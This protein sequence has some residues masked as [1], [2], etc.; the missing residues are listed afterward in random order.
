MTS[1]TVTPSAVTTPTARRV[2]P[3]AV[4]FGLVAAGATTT[5]AA[6]GHAAGISLDVQGAPIPLL[7]FSQVTFGFVLVGLAIAAGLRRWAQDAH[8]AWLVTTLVLTTL[9]FAPDLT[10]DAA[11][12]TRIL[13]M[14]TH[15]TAAAIVI[16]AV[17]SRL[18]RS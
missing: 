10:A 13:L 8:R 17:G 5:V 18:A 4:A 3:A 15:V 1:T 14:T 9:S 16:P 2:W 6:V 11:W 12:S 7:G